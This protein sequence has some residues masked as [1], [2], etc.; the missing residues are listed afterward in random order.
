MSTYQL[1]E[2]CTSNRF[3]ID[4]IDFKTLDNYQ[5]SDSLIQFVEGLSDLYSPEYVFKELIKTFADP[6]FDKESCEQCGT[7]TIEYI[8]EL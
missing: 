4:D 5:Q 7:T 3:E 1:V 8:L 2:S 6:I